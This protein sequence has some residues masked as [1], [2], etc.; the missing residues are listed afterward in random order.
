MFSLK[1]LYQSILIFMVIDLS[2]VDGG[3]GTIKG[4]E[5]NEKVR[6]KDTVVFFLELP[7]LQLFFYGSNN[8]FIFSVGHTIR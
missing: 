7:V 8:N 1:I 3:G 2:I 4:Y 5:V 6:L